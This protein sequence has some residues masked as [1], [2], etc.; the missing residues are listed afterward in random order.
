MQHIQADALGIQE[1]DTSG[2]ITFAMIDKLIEDMKREFP[3]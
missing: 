3:S 1:N 2:T